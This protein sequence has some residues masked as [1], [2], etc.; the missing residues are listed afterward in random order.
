MIQTPTAFQI[1]DTGDGWKVTGPDGFV[2]RGWRP[3]SLAA[4]ADPAIARIGLWDCLD[5]F[6]KELSRKCLTTQ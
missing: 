5:I 2:W 3:E 6:H 1:T 4:L